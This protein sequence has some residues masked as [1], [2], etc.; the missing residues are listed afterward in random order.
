MTENIIDFLKRHDLKDLI[1]LGVITGD[2]HLLTGESVGNLI[3]LMKNEN[4]DRLTYGDDWFLDAKGSFVNRFN[5][6]TNE[7]PVGP[8]SAN[9]E[10]FVNANRHLNIFYEKFNRKIIPQ[11]TRG[12][13]A[14]K[15]PG[16]T[17]DLKM[18]G[19]MKDVINTLPLNRK[20]RYWASCVLPQIV[21]GD[22]FNRL[23]RFLKLVGVPSR[24][25]KGEY[26]NGEIIFAVDYSLR[27]SA[28]DW[29]E[30]KFIRRETTDLTIMLKN[31]NGTHLVFVEAKMYDYVLPEEIRRQLDNQKPVFKAIQARNNLAASDLTHVALLYSV[32][33]KLKKIISGPNE[34][35]IGWSDILNLY[36]DLSGQYFYEM[37][38]IAVSNPQLVTTEETYKLRKSKELGRKYF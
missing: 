10:I 14:D 18:A 12:F 1:A 36:K 11:P 22:R 9:K 5:N 24:F 28:L 3:K 13:V 19:E 32:N 17:S 38:K 2:K 7:T 6:C 29:P 20:G 34:K 35:L 4:V 37:L 8:A 26:D 23:G 27:E 16:R 21:C 15:L 25:I 31:E 33:D 30:A